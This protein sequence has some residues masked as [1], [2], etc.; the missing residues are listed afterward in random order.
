MGS[1]T[2]PVKP[3]ACAPSLDLARKVVIQLVTWPGCGLTRTFN[4]DAG[5][6]DEFMASLLP[7]AVGQL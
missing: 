3:P 6:N 7:E 2:S 5:N 4:V 1:P